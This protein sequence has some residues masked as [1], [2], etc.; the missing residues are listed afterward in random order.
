MNRA[1][2]LAISLAMVTSTLT[3]AAPPDL[4]GSPAAA[5]Y[6]PVGVDEQGLWAEMGEAERELKA[7]KL[8]VRDAAL[9]GYLREVLCK[10][11]T[12]CAS[13]RIYVMRDPAFNASMAPN[14]LMIINTGLLLRIRS[15]SELAA[16]LGHEFV[17]FEHRHS[18]A[19]LKKARSASG[20]AA[21]LGA[22]GGNI[23]ALAIVGSFF[24][25]SQDQ[26][27][28]ADLGGLERLRKAG[29]RTASAAAI[30]SN[31]RA[32]M[33]AT[34]VARKV[35]SRK[36]RRDIFETH[37]AT[38]ERLA[39]LRTN[40]AK[41]IEGEDGVRAYQKA[42]AAHWPTLIDDQVKLNDFGAG[43]YL[44]G[45]LAAEGWTGTLLFARGELY[46]ARGAAGDFGKAAVF[47]REALARDDAPA[48]A[49]RGLGLALPRDGDTA[50]ARVAIDEYLKRKPDASDK[51]MLAMISGGIQ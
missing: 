22:A 2:A 30:W 42:I 1:V 24:T 21:F 17:H 25:F 12:E 44:L 27:R 26:E 51:A 29:Y 33:D 7:S 48:A 20:W 31:L 35:R 45:G 46:R 10:V 28:E 4:Q 36:D 11:T 9:L 47:Y 37:P 40:A 8:L 18:L 43:E 3:A 15:E 16:I 6:L 13:V 41:D 39:Y 38:A 49:W 14:G 32:E 19:L 50:G 5:G 23:V 34:A